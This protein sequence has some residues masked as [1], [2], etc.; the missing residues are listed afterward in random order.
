MNPTRTNLDA[1]GYLLGGVA[2]LA[3]SLVPLLTITLSSVQP[4]AKLMA[5]AYWLLGAGVIWWAVRRFR[6][7][8]ERVAALVGVVVGWYIVMQLLMWLITM[9]SLRF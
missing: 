1:L 9:N 2:L 6:A 5:V 7:L 4:V 8:G 3:I